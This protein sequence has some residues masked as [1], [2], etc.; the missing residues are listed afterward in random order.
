MAANNTHSPLEAPGFDA[1]KPNV[2]QKT[3]IASLHPLIHIKL[4]DLRGE[5]FVVG[6]RAVKRQGKR[7][8]DSSD[9]QNTSNSY[10]ITHTLY[11]LNA[12]SY[13]VRRQNSGIQSGSSRYKHSLLW[14]VPFFPYTLSSTPTMHDTLSTLALPK[15]TAHDTTS[16]ATKSVHRQRHPLRRQCRIY[17]C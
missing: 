10:A 3:S 9:R 1:G 5:I 8:K 15:T 17:I 6:Y 7:M 14:P 16:R 11:T 2:P 13:T 12:A 4:E